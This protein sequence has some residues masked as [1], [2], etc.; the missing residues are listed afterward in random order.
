MNLATSVRL[1]AQKVTR[2]RSLISGFYYI[3]LSIPV[4]TA[5]ALPRIMK[6]QP[7]VRLTKFIFLVLGNQGLIFEPSPA[8][9]NMDVQ[10]MQNQ[11]TASAIYCSNNGKSVFKK[12]G[13]NAI[14]NSKSFGLL[15]PTMNPLLNRE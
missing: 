5:S 15:I 8:Y 3:F 1:Y 7:T 6:T 10:S 14:K 4:E 9:I 2:L 13:N 12:L 11:V